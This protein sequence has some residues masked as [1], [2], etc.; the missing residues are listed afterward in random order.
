MFDSP[1]PQ[2][3]WGSVDTNGDAQEIK[4]GIFTVSI[5]FFHFILPYYPFLFL[6]MPLTHGIICYTRNVSVAILLQGFTNRGT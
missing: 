5:S 1:V 6:L 3:R 2:D 4:T